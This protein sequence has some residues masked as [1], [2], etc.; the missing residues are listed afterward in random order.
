MVPVRRA[1]DLRLDR[2]GEHLRRLDQ[3]VTEYEV[4]VPYTVSHTIENKSEEHVYQ[5]TFTTDPDERIAVIA[6]D[7]L[8]N[9]R[10]ALNYLMVGLVPA[11]R[12]RKTQY[13]LFNKDPFLRDPITRRYVERDPQGRRLWRQY[14]TGVDPK[15]LAVIEEFQP[16]AMGNRPGKVNMLAALNNLS[17]ADKH[18]QLSTVPQGLEDPMRTVW[19]NGTPVVYDWHGVA[20]EGTEVFRSPREVKVEMDGAPVVL[21]RVGGPER[22]AVRISSLQDMLLFVR[23]MIVGLLV[24]YVRR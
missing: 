22:A 12:K 19:L 20:R 18:Y 10:S 14:T 5:L 23:G 9:L 8:H 1:I 7:F 2:A 13:P 21:I 16:Y 15:A 4:S 17:N 11:S 6:G 24:P 3:L